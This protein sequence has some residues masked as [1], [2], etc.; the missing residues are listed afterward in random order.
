QNAMTAVV[1]GVEVYLPLAGLI[2]VEKETARLD[3]ELKTLDKEVARLDK[4]LSN[5]GFLAKAPAEIVAKE[6][7]KLKGYEEKREAVKQRLAYLAT[8]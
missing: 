2:D 4:K 7:E 6:Q 8:I 1:S 5:A 3:K